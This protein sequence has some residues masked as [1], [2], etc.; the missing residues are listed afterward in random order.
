MARAEKTAATMAALRTVLAAGGVTPGW[1]APADDWMDVDELQTQDADPIKLSSEVIDQDHADASQGPS[2]RQRQGHVQTEEMRALRWYIGQSPFTRQASQSP[3]ATP[4][5]SPQEASQSTSNAEATPHGKDVR[6]IPGA[7][8]IGT[9]LNL[10]QPQSRPHRAS[11]SPRTRD[12][13]R[14]SP[15]DTADHTRTSTSAVNTGY[16][17]RPR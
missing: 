9:P 8:Y 7:Y 5:I 6:A 12:T 11:C 4:T 3:S 13:R 2:K 10:L 17:L 1:D 14:R 16:N 15:D